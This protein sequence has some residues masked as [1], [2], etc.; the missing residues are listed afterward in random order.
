MFLGGLRKLSEKS[1]YGGG[2]IGLIGQSKK[3][4]EYRRYGRKVV[5]KLNLD[6]KLRTK[7]AVYT[8]KK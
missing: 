7:Q 8:A 1:N 5:V 3:K 2:M 4:G 6:A